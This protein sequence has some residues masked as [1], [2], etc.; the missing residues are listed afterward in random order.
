MIIQGTDCSPYHTYKSHIIALGTGKTY[1]GRYLSSVC[2]AYL[3]GEL[4]EMEQ[5]VMNE[6]NV[7]VET[8]LLEFRCQSCQRAYLARVPA[9]ESFLRAEPPI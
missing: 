8:T 2:I 5:G 1:C 6:T 7:E 9:P 4:R 3:I